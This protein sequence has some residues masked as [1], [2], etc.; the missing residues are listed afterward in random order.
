MIELLF[1]R[2]RRISAVLLAIPP[3]IYAARPARLLAAS[4]ITYVQGNYSDPQTP[5]T[6]VTASFTKAQ[7]AG[8]LN[9]VV[10]GW[11]D[12]AAAVSTVTDKSGNA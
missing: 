10:V 5:Q 11:N 7:G 12:T 4:T 8:D 6:T 2:H 9:V 3:L 1:G